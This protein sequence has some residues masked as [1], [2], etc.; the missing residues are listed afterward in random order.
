M[1]RANC[2]P[3]ALEW[4]QGGLLSPGDFHEVRKMVASGLSQVE[5]IELVKKEKRSDEG[6]QKEEK[7]PDA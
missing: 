4:I 6:Q 7:E 3:A 2:E 5:A 1:I